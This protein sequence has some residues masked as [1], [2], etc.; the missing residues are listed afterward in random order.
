MWDPRNYTDSDFGLDDDEAFEP[1]D[2]DDERIDVRMDPHVMTVLGPVRPEDLGMTQV[3]EYLLTDSPQSEPGLRLN[4]ISKA[5]EEL[6]SFVTVGGKSIVDMTTAELGRDLLGLLDLAR[7]VPAHVICSVGAT[8]GASRMLE[9]IQ[10]GVGPRTIRPGLIQVYGGEDELQSALMVADSTGLPIYVHGFVESIAS[11]FGAVR[12][13]RSKS[14]S[15]IAVISCDQIGGARIIDLLES[16]LFVMATGI[17]RNVANDQQLARRLVQL[18]GE[19]FGDRLLVSQS[20]RSR[21]QLLAW[22]GSPGLV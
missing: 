16:G 15:V 4:D 12:I 7:R 2:I 20:I 19:G 3:G 21:S 1:E 11:R 13:Q 14:A 6:T 18:E 10:Q 9:E 22:G 5:I 8:G 17:G